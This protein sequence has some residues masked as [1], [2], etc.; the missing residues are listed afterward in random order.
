MT[1]ALPQMLINSSALWYT[2]VVNF[3]EDR[4][5]ARYANSITLYSIVHH[6]YHALFLE[7]DKREMDYT[8]EM[9][10]QLRQ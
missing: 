10:Q 9:T 6:A 1:I 5:L 3:R 2:E 4:K 8:A 7:S